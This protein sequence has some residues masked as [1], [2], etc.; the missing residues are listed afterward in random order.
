MALACQDVLYIVGAWYEALVGIHGGLR[1]ASP[2]S[3]ADVASKARRLISSPQLLGSSRSPS[4]Y[5]VRF[6]VGL[7]GD[8]RRLG[9][10]E[11]TGSN[12]NPVWDSL[13]VIGLLPQ[14]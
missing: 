14:M 4:L 7:G 6:G 5:G 2:V 13:R 9:V 3:S 10:E 12:R 8:E 11:C 1:M